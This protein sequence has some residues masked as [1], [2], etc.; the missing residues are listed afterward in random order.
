VQEKV[1]EALDKIRPLLQRDG[2]DVELVE[3]TPDGVVKVRLKGA[4]GG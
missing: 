3:V 4:C 1:K 2:G